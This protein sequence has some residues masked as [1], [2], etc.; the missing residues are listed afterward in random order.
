MVLYPDF[1]PKML[2]DTFTLYPHF[3]IIGLES[4]HICRVGNEALF[5][6]LPLAGACGG[7]ASILAGQFLLPFSLLKSLIFG[8]FLFHPFVL[9]G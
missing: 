9:V 8:R 2:A 5:T 6:E 3:T 1:Q 7:T 4:P